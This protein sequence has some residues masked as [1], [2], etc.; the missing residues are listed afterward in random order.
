MARA[1]RSAEDVVAGAGD[2][3]PGRAPPAAGRARRRR[4]MS[5][6]V[7][8]AAVVALSAGTLAT[9]GVA[10]WQGM[11]GSSPSPSSSAGSP[12]HLAGPSTP[13]PAE[14]ERAGVR[15]PERPALAERVAAEWVTPY[16]EEAPP[17]GPPPPAPPEPIR[18]RAG[19]RRRGAHPRQQAAAPAGDGTAAL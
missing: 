1:G 2:R 4:V 11:Q 18:A 14:R 10:A 15:T 6:K 13:S 17:P 7:L 5:G 9:A 8:T 16:L 12:A 19:A 3:T